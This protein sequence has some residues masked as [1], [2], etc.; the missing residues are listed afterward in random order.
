VDLVEKSSED[1]VKTMY[2]GSGLDVFSLIQPTGPKQTN[3]EAEQEFL[4]KFPILFLK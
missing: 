4:E 2:A 1:A 3:A